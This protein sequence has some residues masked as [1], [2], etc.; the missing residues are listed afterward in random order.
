MRDK[1]NFERM[2][3]ESLEG[4]RPPPPQL[5]E[6]FNGKKIAELTAEE[7]EQF[8]FSLQ[9]AST[10]QAL[11]LQK[12]RKPE[13]DLDWVLRPMPACL[14]NPDAKN[15]DELVSK[16]TVTPEEALIVT[17]LR[18]QARNT[19]G[20]SELYSLDEEAKARGVHAFT[21]SKPA[22]PSVSELKRLTKLEQMEAVQPAEAPKSQEDKVEAIEMPLYEKI[23]KAIWQLIDRIS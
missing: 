13:E 2:L 10:K 6:T 3:K 16:R 5:P 23:R 17:G 18:K 12:T 8:I 15:K 9:P 7:R 22:E 19:I 14:A 1:K 11:E 20:T 4:H 21:Y